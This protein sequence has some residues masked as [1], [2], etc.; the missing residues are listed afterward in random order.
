MIERII[1]KELFL[2]KC[3]EGIANWGEGGFSQVEG[4]HRWAQRLKVSLL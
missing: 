4:G 1:I 3:R 2:R